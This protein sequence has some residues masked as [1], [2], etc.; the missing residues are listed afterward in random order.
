[1]L[2]ALPAWRDF[3]FEPLVF[4]ALTDEEQPVEGWPV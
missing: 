1:L 4:A 3:T 2:R